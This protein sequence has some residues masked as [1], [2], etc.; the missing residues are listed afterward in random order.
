VMG[1]WAVGLA[2][3]VS[4]ATVAVAMGAYFNRRLGG[5]TGDSYGAIVEWTE[6]ILLCLWSTWV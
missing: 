2:M 4:G 3:A 5:Q 1:A 6:T